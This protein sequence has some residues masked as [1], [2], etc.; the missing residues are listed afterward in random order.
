MTNNLGVYEVRAG[1]VVQSGLYPVMS[2][3]IVNRFA[4]AYK[5]ND[6]ACSL[7]GAAALTDVS[8]S[9]PTVD[10]INIGRAGTATGWLN[11]HLQSLTYY[12]RRLPNAT[13]QSLT[14]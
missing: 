3:N 14:V 1:G 9:V 10:R 11:G 6:F 13:L 12:N 5:A 2:E 8:G 4:V 7:N